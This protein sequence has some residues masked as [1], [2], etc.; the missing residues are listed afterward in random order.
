MQRHRTGHRPVLS[1]QRAHGDVLDTVRKCDLR[2]EAPFRDS[3]QRCELVALHAAE[4]LPAPGLGRA[5]PAHEGRVAVERDCGPVLR[6]ADP[7]EPVRAVRIDLPPAEPAVEDRLPAR[8][9]LREVRLVTPTDEVVTVREPLHVALIHRDDR[10]R[11]DEAADHS[12]VTALYVEPEDQPTRL[13][14]QLRRGLVV[15]ERE[16]AVGPT[17]DVVLPGEAGAATEGEIAS[18]AA[19][20]PEDPSRSPADLVDRVRVAGGDEEVAVRF[21]LDRVDVEIVVDPVG[22]T[23]K[24]VVRLDE[25]DVIDAVPFEHGAAGG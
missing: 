15:K 1:I 11:M 18:L 23:R 5:V 6:A 2:L 14:A 8:P 19:E 12:G 24:A 21:H 22:L 7:L 17:P 10:R 20:P 13:A 3:A 25:P 4:Q 9:E 16:R